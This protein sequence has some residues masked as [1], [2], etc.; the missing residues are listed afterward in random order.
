MNRK[1]SLRQPLKDSFENIFKDFRLIGCFYVFAFAAIYL[2]QRFNAS[3]NI[4]VLLGYLVYT[5]FFYFF[6]IR[7]FYK[8]RPI[9]SKADLVNSLI[10]ISAI[11]L[12]AFAALLLVKIG[13]QLLF[14]L[15]SPLKAFPEV[16]DSLKSTYFSIIKMPYFAWFL[17]GFMFIALSFIFFIPAFAWVSAVIGRDSSITASFARTKGNYLRLIFIFLLIYGALPFVTLFF[18]GSSVLVLSAVSALMTIVQIVV[19]LNIYEFFYKA[20]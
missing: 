16:Y 2:I 3:Q 18:V 1:L 6:F 15:V 10:R 8:M 9:F 17:Y 19:Y 13:F 11:F 5:Y 7:A 4:L 12:L 14:L 20:E